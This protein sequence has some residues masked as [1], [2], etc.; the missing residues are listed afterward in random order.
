M[1]RTRMSVGCLICVVV[2]R[3]FR[4]FWPTPKLTIFILAYTALWLHS[5]FKLSV[6]LNLLRTTY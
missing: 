2:D 6:D 3:E 5:Y 1:L 4:Q